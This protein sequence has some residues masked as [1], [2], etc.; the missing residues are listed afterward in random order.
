MLNLD[1]FALAGT[2]V[3]FNNPDIPILPSG[4]Y[5][6]PPEHVI[7]IASR[8][9]YN[10]L[11]KLGTNPNFLQGL[12]KAGHMDVLEHGMAVFKMTI[13]ASSV[14][15]ANRAQLLLNQMIV[16]HRHIGHLEIDVMD[17]MNEVDIDILI[18]ANLRTWLEVITNRNLYAKNEMY[19]IISH[20]LCH[21]LR[22]IAP[23][24][25]NNIYEAGIHPHSP[26][27]DLPKTIEKD[28]EDVLTRNRQTQLLSV[29]TTGNAKVVPI[30][31]CPVASF[32]D[33]EKYNQMVYLVSGVS[34]AFSHQHV[35]HR[36]LS[37]SQLSQRY[38]DFVN[39]QNGDFVYPPGELT[40]EQRMILKSLFERIKHDYELLRS[41]GMKKEDARCIL[42]NAAETSLVFS[43][44]SDGLTHYFNLRT[45]KD[46]QTEIR[47]IA[48]IAMH[49]YN[50]VYS[51]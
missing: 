40:D 47:E 30:G 20:C 6:T 41:T 36:K 18:G 32:L 11:D 2:T 46:A 29:T 7:E 4:S 3:L 33:R 13:H 42:P 25:F 51:D 10:S 5:L 24:I 34:R 14:E 16:T 21:S 50:E 1:T 15:E 38:V 26:S 43:G 37:F 12:M 27:L 39:K 23:H 35:R 49:M 45:A 9:C 17:D 22:N 8:L 48:L 28:V 44:T 31:Y 19:Q